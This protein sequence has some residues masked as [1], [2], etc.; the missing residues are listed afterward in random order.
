MSPA[1][2]LTSAVTAGLITCYVNSSAAPSG[3]YRNSQFGKC[4]HFFLSILLPSAFYS[5]RIKTQGGIR[6]FFPNA[7]FSF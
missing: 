4:S 6:E 3:L 1:L 5:C 7:A 2:A